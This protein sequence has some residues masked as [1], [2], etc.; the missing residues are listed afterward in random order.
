MEK[1]NANETKI[2]F[3]SILI[4]K[5]MFGLPKVLIFLFYPTIVT[6]CV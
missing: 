3:D 5:L 2:T 4:E 1:M 6:K